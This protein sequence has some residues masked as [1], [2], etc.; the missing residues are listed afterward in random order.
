MNKNVYIITSC[1]IFSFKTFKTMG[2]VNRIYIVE[3]ASSDYILTLTCH[4]FYIIFWHYI[5]QTVI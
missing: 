2:L 4:T 1:I 3:I 5:L